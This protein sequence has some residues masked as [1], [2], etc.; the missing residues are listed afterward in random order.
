MELIR[1]DTDYAVRALLAISLAEH[2]VTVAD[3]AD[4]VDAPPDFLHKILRKLGK[5]GI[6]SA[7]RGVKGGFV[8]EKKT[9]E[10][11][12]LDVVEAV[13]GRIALN[14]CLV[15]SQA[16]S[17]IKKCSVRKR[18]EVAQDGLKKLLR[19]ITLDELLITGKDGR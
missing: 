16:C 1:R 3:I 4:D 7:K 12:L 10:I 6:V 5:A 13:Q 19:D 9:N 17:M 18:L 15:D 14:R 11:S 2:L 8:L